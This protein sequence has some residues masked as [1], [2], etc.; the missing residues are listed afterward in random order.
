M[1][2]DNFQLGHVVE[3]GL[4]PLAL[5]VIDIEKG[6]EID[7]DAIFGKAPVLRGNPAVVSAKHDNHLGIGIV[8]GKS[9]HFARQL[10]VKFA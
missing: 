4:L 2:L 6:I 10:L 3:I 9:R 8:L 7:V 1:R 5:I